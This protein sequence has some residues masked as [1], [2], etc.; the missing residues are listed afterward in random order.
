MKKLE[1]V[2]K[3]INSIVVKHTKNRSVSVTAF[4]DDVLVRFRKT[5]ITSP[6]SVNIIIKNKIQETGLKMTKEA[7]LGL[8]VCLH[9]YFN[10]IEPELINP[11]KA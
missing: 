5:N 4:N 8:Y 2:T 10:R 3:Y 7:A 9:D 6:A 11:P 1:R